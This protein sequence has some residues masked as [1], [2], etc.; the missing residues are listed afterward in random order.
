MVEPWDGP[1]ISKMAKSAIEGMRRRNYEPTYLRIHPN[2]WEIVLAYY[3]K[4]E[5]KPKSEYKR[6][7]HGVPV[8]LDEA[9]DRGDVRAFYENPQPVI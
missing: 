8:R 1:H 5:G 9:Q 3:A 2:D 4:L 6:T 7:L